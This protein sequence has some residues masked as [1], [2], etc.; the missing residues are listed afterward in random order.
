MRVAPLMMLLACLCAGS[1]GC[2]LFSKKNNG[3]EETPF[4]AKNKGNN[5]PKIADTADPI[6]GGSVKGSEIDGVLAGQV[7]DRAT[8]KPVDAQIR[9]VYL[10]DGKD[11]ESPIDVA[12]NG[13]GY[14][15]IHGLKSGKHYR[16][17]ARSKTGER[18]MT[19][20]SLAQV[21]NVHLL[22]RVSEDFN[23]TPLPAA[24]GKNQGKKGTGPEK[25]ASAETPGWQMTP[26]PGYP[27]PS[28]TPWPQDK[29]HKIADQAAVKPPLADWK[30]APANPGAAPIPGSPSIKISAPT[31]APGPTPIPSC[32]LV[33]KRLDNF[34]LR[35][36]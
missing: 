29:N 25:Q 7:I 20:V 16:L 9:W 3:G 31:I 6:M 13:Q 28:T 21:P 5:Q 2:Q 35:D 19:G 17:V 27:G 14:F 4:L 18:V 33:G 10:D 32:V 30:M 12:V 1:T 36:I 22:I 11:A 24:P 34:A 15:M 8:G 26:Q 23:N